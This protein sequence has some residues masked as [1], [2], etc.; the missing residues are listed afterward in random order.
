[1]FKIISWNILA[2]EFV[3]KNDYLEFDLDFI[4]NRDVRIKKIIKKLRHENTDIILLQE[5]MIYEFNYLKN[6]LTNYYFSE[7]C[8]IDWN[9]YENNTESG[10]V[11]MFKKSQFSHDFVS[12]CL[13]YN[14]STFG[15]YVMLYTKNTKDVLHIFNVHL[16]DQFYQT[17]KNQINS[18]KPLFSRLKYCILG[19]DFNEEYKQQS[20][21]YTIKDFIATNNNITYFI[22][23]YMNIDNILTKGFLHIK[24]N[25]SYDYTNTPKQKLFY[26]FGSDHIPI[27]IKINNWLNKMSD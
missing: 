10:N 21:L 7:L 13:K 2:V 15:L 14:N 24:H 19:G 22:E 16:D 18:I 12:N 17:R 27:V 26:L 3:E 6:H 1:M 11:I 4:N 9:N 20:K 25:V 5:V 8:K 23:D